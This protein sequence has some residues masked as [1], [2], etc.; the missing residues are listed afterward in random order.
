[1]DHRVDSYRQGRPEGV[2]AEPTKHSAYYPNSYEPLSHHNARQVPFEVAK[3]WDGRTGG[4]RAGLRH[5]HEAG[6]SAGLLGALES[7]EV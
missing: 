1:M 2:H 4:G 6:P 7:S 3:T 5:S